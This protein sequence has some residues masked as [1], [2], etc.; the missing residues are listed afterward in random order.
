[1]NTTYPVAVTSIIFC[2]TDVAH[3]S[4][5]KLY[6][7]LWSYVESLDFVYSLLFWLPTVSFI[8]FLC[9]LVSL[10]LIVF[11]E[12]A[13]PR[14]LT[15]IVLYSGIGIQCKE[16]CGTVLFCV[17]QPGREA[18]GQACNNICLLGA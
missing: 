3:V 2:L 15:L 5:G 10:P 8:F 1:M 12:G 4:F 13:V 17:F 7:K 18:A 14:P 6:E 16:I 9:F 11:S